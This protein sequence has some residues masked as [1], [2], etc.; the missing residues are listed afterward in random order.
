MMLKNFQ[1]GND[2]SVWYKLS[3]SCMGMP[4][5]SIFGEPSLL[6]KRPP[7]LLLLTPR[8]VSFSAFAFLLKDF[9]VLII[10]LRKY[11]NNNTVL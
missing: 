8:P 9:I 4:R 3:R 5:I 1:I 10:S 6:K 2:N 11:S 7:L